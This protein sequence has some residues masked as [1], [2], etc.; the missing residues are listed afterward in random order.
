MVINQVLCFAK[1]TL[2]FMSGDIPIKLPTV[3]V[4]L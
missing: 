3:T 4:G 1:Y 2:S